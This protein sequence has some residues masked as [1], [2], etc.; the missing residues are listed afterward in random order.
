MRR[1]YKL[2]KFAKSNGGIFPA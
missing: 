2:F 1:V